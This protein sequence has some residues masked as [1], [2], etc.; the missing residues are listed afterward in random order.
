MKLFALGWV[1]ALISSLYWPTL[2]TVPVLIGVAL[3][4][5]YCLYR[6]HYLIVGICA[7]ACWLSWQATQYYQ[8]A[9]QLY[10]HNK[11]YTIQGRVITV[12]TNQYRQSFLLQIDSSSRFS[13]K[14]HNRLIRLSE[15]R[16]AGKSFVH[17]R[18]GDVIRVN[19]SV[20]PAHST[21]NQGGFNYQRWMLAKG[22]IGQGSVYHMTVIRQNATER[23]ILISRLHHFYQSVPQS[24]VIN[25]LTTGD[26]SQISQQEKL[27]WMKSGIGHLLA[28]SGLHLGILAFWGYWLGRLLMIKR[29]K[30]QQFLPSVL[31]ILLACGYGY[32]ANWPLSAQR[33][34]VMLCI[35]LLSQNLNLS[36]SRMDSWLFALFGVTLIWP[37]SI[38]S[39]GLWLSFSAI[40]I[41]FLL[42][43]WCPW[44]RWHRMLAIQ[45]GLLLLML[46]I[47]VCLFGY[48]PVLSLPLNL[49]CIPIF[50]FL[51]IP[52][53]LVAV[54]LGC[55]NLSLSQMIFGWVGHMLEI[56]AHVLGL[57][58]Q[59]TALVWPVP[60]SQWVELFLIL[61][62]LGLTIVMRRYSFIAG[63]TLWFI[64]PSFAS[65]E[66]DD[67]WVHFLDVGQGLAIVIESH[68][69][70]VIYDTGNRYPTG[71]SYAK[72]VIQPFLVSHKDQSVDMIVVSHDD[73]D[74]SG[75]YPFLH[76]TY[77]RAR[78]IFGDDPRF[79]W[80]NCHGT[81]RW[82]ELSLKLIQPQL[83]HTSNNNLSCLLL[84]GDLNHQILLTGDIETNAEQWLGRHIHHRVDG[85]SVPH[86][87]SR[88]SSTLTWLKSISPHWAV[89]SRGFMNTYGFPHPS[90]MA[91]Y[92]R[93]GIMTYD[94]A[95]DGQIS[96]HV[97]SSGV[98]QMSYRENLRPFWYNRLQYK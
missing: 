4:A 54:A 31:S 80:H 77:P 22:I 30:G 88:T 49:I 7:A 65:S 3:F 83:K 10:Q 91:R 38:L 35:W 82:Q 64:M 19:A 1:V 41:L 52:F 51:I 9:D 50:S 28:I 62:I 13:E 26:R 81:I 72:A 96:V 55:L 46:P 29:R 23:G 20:K 61:L 27:I 47:Q 33:A 94:T 87:G 66:Q 12:S 21:L 78:T 60:K 18:I 89:Y 36:I 16:H 44:K 11:H 56:M 79:P 24:G 70:V 97:T 43:W 53:L 84:I 45:V 90:V 95:R 93:L 71:F 42:L 74:H 8:A 63:L 32:L 15:Y 59:N 5:C 76:R 92:H 98:K 25:A 75:G 86:H 69:H 14:L 37:L 39:E 48:V 57:L 85:I 68:H 40:F 67:W 58:A 17:V 6:H 34:A 73:R 2:P